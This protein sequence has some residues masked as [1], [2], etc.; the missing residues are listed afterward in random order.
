MKGIFGLIAAL[1]Y[2]CVSYGHLDD[3]RL[4]N[5]V[6]V[7]SD[8]IDDRVPDGKCKISGTVT[9]YGELTAGSEVCSYKGKECV[10]T[11][12]KGAFS[13]VID[14]N[15]VYVYAS[16]IGANTAYLQNYKFKSGHHIVLEFGLQESIT[17]VRKP[18]IYLYSDVEVDLELGLE[19]DVELTFTYPEYEDGW[20]VNL[21]PKEGLSVDGENYPYL[22]WEGKDYG[23]L[24][25]PRQEGR[26]VG[27]IIRTDTVISYLENKMTSYGLNSTEVADFITFWGPVLSQKKYAFV[28]FVLDEEYNYLAAIESSKPIDNERRVFMMYESFDSKPDLYITSSQSEPKEF[29]RGGL[30]LIEW[31]GAEVNVPEL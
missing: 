29:S 3:G 15:E 12:K 5:P 1:F 10:I 14:T 21:D 28:H 26:I 22:F 19:T 20:N 13:L 24:H 30:T 9:F 4:V 23:N 31:G 18:I 25:Y 17:V 7:I 11:D 6:K 2:F 8:T 27:E 16:F